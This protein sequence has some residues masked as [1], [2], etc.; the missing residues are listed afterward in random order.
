M[1]EIHKYKYRVL[2][3]LE[4]NGLDIG[5]DDSGITYRCI[6]IDT[7]WASD[8]VNAVLDARNLYLFKDGVFDWVNASHVLED[9]E[10]TEQALKEWIRVLRIGGHLIIY[11]P[12]KNFYPNIGEKYGNLGHKHDFIP[13]DITE[14]LLSLG[15]KIKLCATFGCDKYDYENRANIEYSFLIVAQK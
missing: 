14:I 3:Y 8:Y 1:G 10:D 9:I 2:K 13:T 5:V 6:G 12:H 7:H 15:M 11:C 4:G